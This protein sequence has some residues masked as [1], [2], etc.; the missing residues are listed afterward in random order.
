MLGY[1]HNDHFHQLHWILIYAPFLRDLENKTKGSMDGV[2]AKLHERDEFKG[3]NE[4]KDRDELM[5]MTELG[6]MD[7]LVDRDGLTDGMN[8]WTGMNWRMRI[9]WSRDNLED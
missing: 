1:N 6:D 9:N 4:S 8:L 2:R 5:H 3:G 7:E